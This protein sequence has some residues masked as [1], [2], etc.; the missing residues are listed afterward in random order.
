LEKGGKVLIHDE[1]GRSVALAFILA[2]MINNLQI[3]LKIGLEKLKKLNINHQ[4]NSYFVS[5]LE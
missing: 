5:Q 4:L 2:Y 1:S 3:P